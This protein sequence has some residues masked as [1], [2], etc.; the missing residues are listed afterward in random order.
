MTI[1]EEQE[2]ELEHPN[3]V[4]KPSIP[5]CKSVFSDRLVSSLHKVQLGSQTWN[6]VKI[7]P[8][9]NDLVVTHQS[10]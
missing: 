2:F 8:P 9:I 3:S 5:N 4:Q 10:S 6:L 1:Q 7:K